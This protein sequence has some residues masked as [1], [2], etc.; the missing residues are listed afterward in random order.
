LL[1][2]AF[3]VLLESLGPVERAVFLLREVFDYGYEE[4]AAVVG[5][6]PDNCRLIAVRARRQVEAHKPRFEAS[7]RKR[8]ELARRFLEAVEGDDTQGLVRLLAADVVVYGDGGGK[9]SAIL[10]PVYG[11]ERVA[12]LLGQFRPWFQR[13]GVRTPIP[14]SF[15]TSCCRPIPT[16]CRTRT[17]RGLRWTLD[18]LLTTGR[19]HAATTTARCAACSP[20]ITAPSRASPTPHPPSG[21][22]AGLHR[23]G[24]RRGRRRWRRPSPAV[25]AQT[26][27]FPGDPPSDT[28]DCPYLNVTTPARTDGRKLP[29]M[30]WIHGDGERVAP[31]HQSRE[32]HPLGAA[33]P[34]PKGG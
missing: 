22:C 17:R 18:P 5:K 32:A 1:S 26:G 25:R 29:V 3:P 31:M 24:P 19:P 8:E 27:G 14:T 33:A 16:E 6:S 20:A 12:R 28:E 10:R 11:R 30:V 34:L 23:G 9:A 21:R 13:L 2:L 7:R 4:I 15:A